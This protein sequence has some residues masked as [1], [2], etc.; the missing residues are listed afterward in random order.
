M[1]C[2]LALEDGILA[3]GE[4][5]GAPGTATGEVVFNTAM[6]GYQEILTD[7]SYCR[8][9]VTMTAPHIG[10]YGVNAED[11]ESDGTHL[12]G[13]VVRQCARRYSNQRA[14]GGLPEYLASSG[15]V[16]I[17]GVDTRAITRRLR[18][19]GAMRGAISTEV[20]NDE[21]LVALARSAPKMSGL[22]LAAEV[23]PSGVRRWKGLGQSQDAAQ[24]RFNIVAIDCGIK[25]S[26]LGHL[27]HIGGDVL[28]VPGTADAATILARRP[29]GVLVGSGPGDPEAV[30]ATIQTLRDLVG[31]VP[32]FGVC[33]GHQ[34]LALALGA[35]TYKLKF[36]H[37]GANHPVLNTATGRVEITSQNH[38]FA[39]SAESLSQAGLRATHTNLYDGSLEGFA[40]HE[41]P[42]FAVQFHPEAA[43]GPHDAAY[44]F[45]CFAELM[46]T[47]GPLT[48]EVFRRHDS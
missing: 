47:P 23:M 36:G 37:H 8:Q 42:L 9:I 14:S 44:L 28:V 2:K 10:N 4:S 43:P 38:G 27:A 24:R 41:E 1:I 25:Q 15:V 22:D 17:S 12:A 18:T 29:D 21:E 5:I 16:A 33:L 11:V 6:S 13:L 45:N 46:R 34:M 19:T 32:I 35:R 3:V 7:P 40:H 31:R 26:I 20:L 39:V 48:E 30:T